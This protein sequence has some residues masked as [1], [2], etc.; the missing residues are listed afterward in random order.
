[1]TM[2]CMFQIEYKLSS[3]FNLNQFKSLGCLCNVFVSISLLLFENCWIQ[4]KCFCFYFELCSS[5]KKRLAN[6]SALKLKV[7]T[8][9]EIKKI[10]SALKWLKQSSFS[11]L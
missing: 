1:L 4:T 5:I 2:I 6:G 10:V 3:L 11:V 7:I 9:K 8:L